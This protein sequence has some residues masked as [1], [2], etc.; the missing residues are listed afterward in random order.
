MY[1]IEDHIDLMVDFVSKKQNPIILEFG[2]ERGFST[3]KFIN[4]AEKNSGKVF[5]V[6]IADCSKVSNSR[7]WK[8]LQSNDLNVDYILNQFSEIKIGGVDLIYIDSYHEAEHVQ[9]LIYYYFTYLKYD[10]AIFVDDI[11]SFPLRLRKKTWNSIIYDLTLD[12]VKEFYESNIDNC[13]LKV[14][15]NNKQNGLAMIH[16]TNKFMAEPNKIK[17]I[18]NYNF[19]FKILYPL[20]K[21]VSNIYKSIFKKKF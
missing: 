16:K 1:N 14:F 9:K 4:F 7:S 11:D 2:V 10:G 20:L 21:K 13:S 3:K 6:D 17:K 19:I 8:F 5:S 18:W 15:Y 12:C